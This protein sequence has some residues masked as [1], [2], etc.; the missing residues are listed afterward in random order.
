[1]TN[2]TA[3]RVITPAP[4]N[5]DTIKFSK[6][7]NIDHRPTCLTG[8]SRTIT[9]RGWL[10]PVTESSVALP[11]HAG[12]CDARISVIGFDASFHH[13]A[14][15]LPEV[16]ADAD[17]AFRSRARTEWI[18]LSNIRVPEVRSCSRDERIA[19]S[20][21]I[22][23]ARLACRRIEAADVRRVVSCLRSTPAPRPG[24]K[25]WIARFHC[26]Q[27]CSSSRS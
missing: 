17:A 9:A 15:A 8:H 14:T 16:R 27:P 2:F 18:R 25:L 7:V 11:P 24:R 22:R 19:G 13:R 21:A 1:M 10:L 23:H 20:N 6:L 12:K 4:R 26:S 3:L 5:D